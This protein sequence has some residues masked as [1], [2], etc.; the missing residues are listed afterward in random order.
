MKKIIDGTNMTLGRLASYAAK[1]AL[2]GEDITIL[3]CENVI[4]TGNKKDILKEF[5]EK[6]SKIG[7]GHHGP[8]YSLDI[9]KIIKRTIRGMIP[10]HRKG[11][12]KIAYKRIKC[13]KG[14]P[15]EFKSSEKETSN[16]INQGKYFRI[17]ELIKWMK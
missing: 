14:I 17:G 6:K 8:K 9:E 15:S 12:G 1:E 16:K 13:Y 5:R 7:S 3:N 4:I 2:K 11:I 10:N